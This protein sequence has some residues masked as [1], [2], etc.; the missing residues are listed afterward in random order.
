MLDQSLLRTVP[1]TMGK[2]KAPEDQR[3]ERRSGLSFRV[4]GGVVVRSWPHHDVP[5]RDLPAPPGAARA[6]SDP[7]RPERARPA[8]SCQRKAPEEEDAAWAGP[9][10]APGISES[11][12]GRPPALRHRRDRPRIVVAAEWGQGQLESARPDRCSEQNE[13]ARSADSLMGAATQGASF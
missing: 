9:E 7:W 1:V 10:S 2:R 12:P 8:G 13:P 11:V 4:L 5:S 6:G 3:I